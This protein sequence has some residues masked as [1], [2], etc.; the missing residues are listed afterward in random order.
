MCGIFA[1]LG[2]E[3]LSIREVLEVMRL[4]EKDQEPGEKNPVGGDGA[5]IAY[6]NQAKQFSLLKVGRTNG[7]PVTELSRRI[8][9]TSE[10]SILILAHV[11]HAS[12]EFQGTIKYPEC[13][14]P[15][16][17]TCTKNLTVFTG[18]NGYL[19]NYQQLKNNLPKTHHFESEKTQLVDSEII[20]HVFEEALIEL[21]DP[22][23]AA[24]TL[25]EQTQGTQTQ[26][27]TIVTL[28]I[29]NDNAHVNAIQK[30]KTRG[31]VIWTNPQNE[32]I[33]CTR[34]K[35]TQETL[36]HFLTRNHYQKIINITRNDTTNIEAHF[37]HQTKNK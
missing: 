9:H 19:T 20:S 1:F 21:N 11:R 32:A 7:S 27:N 18:H 2:K 6:L 33:I 15:Y 10:S 17:P 3:P 4:L 26:G 12:P 25:Y 23:K 24:H 14:Q 29:R 5:G 13:T 30:G 34:E 36:R 8:E 28:A 37:N 16:R 35:P 31:L 22:T